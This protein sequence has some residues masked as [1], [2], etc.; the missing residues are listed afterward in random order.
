M[1]SWE[2][3]QVQRIEADR[4]EEQL[5]EAREEAARA[6]AFEQ[7]QWEQHQEMLREEQRQAEEDFRAEDR[8]EADGPAWTPVISEQDVEEARRMAH[9]AFEEHQGRQVEEMVEGLSP[10]Q[11]AR[12]R[13]RAEHELGS[14]DST[15]RQRAERVLHR[16]MGTWYTDRVVTGPPPSNPAMMPIRAPQD[17]APPSGVETPRP[18]GIDWGRLARSQQMSSEVFRDAINRLRA[19]ADATNRRNVDEHRDAQAIAESVLRNQMEAQQN[20]MRNMGRD[21]LMSGLGSGLANAAGVAGLGNI[22]PAQS[23]RTN[24]AINDEGVKLVHPR[25][26][27]PFLPAKDRRTGIKWLTWVEQNIDDGYIKELNSKFTNLGDQMKTKKKKEERLYTF[28]RRHIGTSVQTR[29]LFERIRIMRIPVAKMVNAAIKGNVAASFVAPQNVIHQW[30]LACRNEANRVP[31]GYTVYRTFENRRLEAYLPSREECEL[32]GTSRLAKWK[33]LMKH[34]QTQ[35]RELRR[36]RAATFNERFDRL[37][38]NT[39]PSNYILQRGAVKQLSKKK[40]PVAGIKCVGIEIE[41]LLPE[42]ADMTMFWPVA[43]FIEIGSDGSVHPDKRDQRAAEI[44]VVCPQSMLR[45]V[46]G[47]L[48]KVLNDMGASVNKSCGLHVHI[49]QRH[50]NADE[51][52][53]AFAN[54]VRAQNLLMQVVPKSRRENTFCTK[55]RGTDFEEA[56]MGPRYKAINAAAYRRHKT[57]EVRLMNGT[58]NAEKIINWTETL[59]AIDRG[60]RTLRCP[61]DFDI[62]RKYWQLSEENVRWLKKRQEK[63]AKQEEEKVTTINGRAI[64]EI[65]VDDDIDPAF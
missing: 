2:E 19:A 15:M 51:V 28:L 65:I 10:D 40:S 54:L 46:I 36:V 21:A 20:M 53:L 52:S 37:R 22:M 18:D 3:E 17:V 62:A 29:N 14:S 31:P 24:I 30:R 48:C 33:E 25:A 16:L 50:K 6:E 27:S 41:C 13:E 64:S 57:I 35:I 42:K 45:E 43:R 60:L 56:M 59:L 11:M 61:K 34:F 1:P 23:D 47:N 44:R 4:V 5:A 39:R 7:A 12:L 32:N 63:F 26:G 8:A 55:Q 49:D 9:A 58:V 38:I